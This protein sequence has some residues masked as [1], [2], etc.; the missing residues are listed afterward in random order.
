MQGVDGFTAA[1]Q[2]AAK[3]VGRD[4]PIQFDTGIRA[5]ASCDDCS[6]DIL[7]IGSKGK[8]VTLDDILVTLSTISYDDFCEDRSYYFEGLYI[9]G[10]SCG[11]SWGS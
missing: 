1:I 7:T 8:P 11:F 9:Y 2:F 5:H 4:G 10:D 6:S 3:M